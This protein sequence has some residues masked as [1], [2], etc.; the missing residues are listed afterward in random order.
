MSPNIFP[1]LSVLS[2][3]HSHRQATPKTAEM[4]G[5]SGL[6]LN[7]SRKLCHIH[8]GEVGVTSKVGWGSTF[9]FFFKVKRSEHPQDHDALTEEPDLDNV[10]SKDL[11]STPHGEVGEELISRSSNHPRAGEAVDKLARG[12]SQQGG[13]APQKSKVCV[14]AQNERGL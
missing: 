2:I 5:G 7:I 9:G 12:N 1:V 10:Q 4:Y 14:P 13:S 11:G 3:D 6:G 8:G